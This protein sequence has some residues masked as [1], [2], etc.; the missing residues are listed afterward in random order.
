[1][2]QMAVLHKIKCK[3]TSKVRPIIFGFIKTERPIHALIQALLQV[4]GWITP[5]K[6]TSS[7]ILLKSILII[8]IRIYDGTSASTEENL[9]NSSISKPVF[10]KDG[11]KLFF[12]QGNTIQ[13]RVLGD[14]T[15]ELVDVGAAITDLRV[16]IETDKVYY[17]SGGDLYSYDDSSNLLIDASDTISEFEVIPYSMFDEDQIDDRLASGVFDSKHIAS[18]LFDDTS[19]TAGTLDEDEL[20]N[21]VITGAILTNNA[22]TAEKYNGTVAGT[23][24]AS[25]AITSSDYC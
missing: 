9:G 15:S 16:S 3:F 6:Q 19:F 2:A 4:P 11:T 25:Q 5:L 13:R 12:I 18:R 8:W 10:N 1:M 7:L 14:S 23:K 17:I 20:A 21:S 22:I 24:I